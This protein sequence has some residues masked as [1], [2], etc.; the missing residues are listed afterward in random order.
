[1]RHR[2]RALNWIALAGAAMLLAAACGTRLPKSELGGDASL[3]GPRP[4]PVTPTGPGNGNPA[5]DVGVTSTE[6]RV[7]LIVSETGPL[8]AEALSAPMYGALAYFQSLNKR[9]GIHGRTVHVIVC[10]DGSTGAGNRACA[11]QLIQ[12]DKVFAFVGNSILNFAA[13]SYVS[14]SDVPDVGG[15]PIGNEYDQY[16]HLYSIQGDSYPRTGQFVGYNGTLVGGTA[17]YHHF[18]VAVGGKV[19]GVVYYN[20]SD[21]Q[22][23]GD[24]T[25]TGLEVE[26][27]QVVR[28]QV[29]LAVPNF[30]A[31][32]VD[33]KARHVDT[34]F[35]ALDTTGNV[36]LCKAMEAAGLTV[37]AKVT[38]VQNWTDSVRSDFASTPKCRN[39]IYATAQ[40]RNYMDTH[41]PAVARFRADI[42]AAYPARED[43]LSIWEEEGWEAGDWFTAAA[44]S[45][46]A[47]L[48]RRCVEAFLNRP[49]PF[50]ADGLTTGSAFTVSPLSTT[51]K[52]DC[53]NVAQWQDSAY[54]GHGGWVTRT[55]NGDFVC[56][57]TPRITYKA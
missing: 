40:D 54:G 51:P 18:K 35:D 6:I 2:L 11:Q 47:D 10:D 27:Y 45:C 12:S 26:G 30:D 31:A 48:S 3:G 55:P 24:L 53:M 37:K 17:V 50:T 38:T 20:Q 28:E 23:Y 34:V 33:M 16:P 49:Q 42:Q 57:T 25:V 4:G 44:S 32:A 22:R 46:G 1:M 29:D 56:Y 13:A 14:S 9:G 52:Q 19:A 36:S 15:Q 7:G 8:G 21:S 5:S 43:K 39:A 41:Y